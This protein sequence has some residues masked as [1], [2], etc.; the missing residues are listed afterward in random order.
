MQTSLKDLFAR[1]K[2][3]LSRESYVFVGLRRTTQFDELLRRLDAFSSVTIEKDEISLVLKCKIW[4][5]YSSHY[6]EAKVSGPYRLIAFDIAMDLDVCGYFA[7]ISKLL[8]EARIS[9]MPVS[10]YLR[11]YILVPE[12]SYRKAVVTINRFLKKQR[13]IQSN[14]R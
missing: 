11:D 7:R 9:I 8:E 5:R 14:R 2:L 1:T 12:P 6:R 10:T 13:R 4:N 3:R